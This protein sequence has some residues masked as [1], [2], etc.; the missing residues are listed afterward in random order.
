MPALPVFDMSICIPIA[1]LGISLCFGIDTVKKPQM[2]RNGFLEINTSRQQGRH[3]QRLPSASV[4]RLLGQ[5]PL[6]VHGKR[7]THLCHCTD[8]NET[9]TP[10]L[11]LAMAGTWGCAWQHVGHGV[12]DLVGW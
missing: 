4:R 11:V 7:G 5:G 8:N 3:R 10:E 12:A 2:S 1:A 9:A 6:S